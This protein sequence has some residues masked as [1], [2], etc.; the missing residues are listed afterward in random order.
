M[1]FVDT[2]PLSRIDAGAVL[3]VRTMTISIEGKNSYTIK[4]ILEDTSLRLRQEKLLEFW[5]KMTESEIQK[6]YNE[7][8]KREYHKALKNRVPFSFPLRVFLLH[9]AFRVN[10]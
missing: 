6:H 9:Q 3:K 1:C 2:A 7:K 8:L 5:C 10:L 4:R